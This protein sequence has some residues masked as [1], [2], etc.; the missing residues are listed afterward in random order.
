[1]DLSNSYYTWQ[2]I[3]IKKSF[4]ASN[5][6]SSTWGRELI[7]QYEH[8]YKIGGKLAQRFPELQPIPKAQYHSASI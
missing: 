7:L 8:S 5:L 1:M 3:F 4:L 2:H 6:Y